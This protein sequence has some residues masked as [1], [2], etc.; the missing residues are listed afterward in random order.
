LQNPRWAR[1]GLFI[2]KFQPVPFFEKPCQNQL[3]DDYVNF[4][5]K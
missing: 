3:F 1:V 4:W 2:L 5:G